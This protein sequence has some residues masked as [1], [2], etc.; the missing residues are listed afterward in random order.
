MEPAPPA[1]SLARFKHI[2]SGAGYFT[3][4]KGIVQSIFVHQ[5]PR[6]QLIILRPGLAIS[7]LF[8]DYACCF[9]GF[10]QVYGNEI[11]SSHNIFY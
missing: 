5:A 3:G 7:A 11:G 10:W 1:D 6:A 9:R 2:N 8:S 4:F